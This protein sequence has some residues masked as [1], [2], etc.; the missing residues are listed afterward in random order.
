MFHH[1]ILKINEDEILFTNY[2]EITTIMRIM[3]NEQKQVSKI[4]KKL[5]ILKKYVDE[6]IK[7]HHDNLLQK[8]SRMTKTLQLLRQHCQFSQMRQRVEAYIKKCYNCKKN[9]HVTHASY[10]EI[11][12]QKLLIAS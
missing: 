3:K 5:Q 10:E 12:Y 6:Y 11:Q 2:R 9:K 4:Q 7:K 8:H 1:N